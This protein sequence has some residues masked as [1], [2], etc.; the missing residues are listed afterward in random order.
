MRVGMVLFALGFLLF[1]QL[2]SLPSFY[3][4]F[5]IISLGANLAG[6]MPST[7]AVV[8]WFSRYRSR[9]LGISSVGFALG[10]LVAPLIIL[11]IT[12]LGW[13]QTAFASALIVL[14]VGL[15]LT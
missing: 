11:S 5:M 7:V 14:V 15:P 3:V 4:G 1:S 10:G 13:R 2:W 6:F 8:N 9:A 12:D